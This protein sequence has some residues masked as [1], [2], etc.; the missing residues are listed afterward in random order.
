MG[1]IKLRAVWYALSGLLFAGSFFSLA[2][3]G[4]N[5]G[6]DFTGGSL[7]A[8]R[9]EERPATLEIERMLQPYD[10]GKVIIQP[11]GDT[12]VN[13]RSKS[14]N[15]ETHQNIISAFQDQYPNVT[16]LRF[17]SIGPSVGAELRSKSLWALAISFGLILVYIAY[18]Y[19][20]V[21]VPV[22][23]WKYGVITLITALHDVVIPLGVFSLL[24]KFA[25]VEV[26]TPFVVA[27]LTVLGYSINDTIVVFDRIRENLHRLS[28]RFEEIVGASLT[29]TYVRSLNTSLTTLFAIV[30]VYLFGGESLRNFALTFI[31]GVIAGTYSSIFI[32][33]PLLVTWQKLSSRNGK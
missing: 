32:S 7:L 14:L 8:L 31:I 3:Y 4:L 26:G 21:S 24:G 25:G 30:A 22:Q 23:N 27:V 17:D 9:F 13:I 18:A 12:D 1:I 29:Q 19:R 15:E 16:E 10:T 28:G 5:F 2:V 6:I 20:K 33:S 11:V